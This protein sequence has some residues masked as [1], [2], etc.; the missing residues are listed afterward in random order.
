M[1]NKIEANEPLTPD[2]N[3]LRSSRL[4]L[5]NRLLIGA[6]T[7]DRG[8]YSDHHWQTAVEEVTIL[9]ESIGQEKGEQKHTEQKA[10]A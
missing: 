5:A 4:K 10:A 2:P 1:K 9:I 6:A 3:H 7:A 8:L